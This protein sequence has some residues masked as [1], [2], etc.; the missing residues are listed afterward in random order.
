MDDSV[1]SLSLF[2]PDLDLFDLNRVEVLR[3]P[4][5]T[6]YGAGSVGGTIRYITNRPELERDYGLVEAELNSI[7]GG[8]AGWHLKGM[9]NVALSDS[10]ALRL[11][12]YTT[13]Y[14]GYIDA[15]SESGARDDDVNTWR[16]D[17]CSPFV[18]VG[19]E[20]PGL[21]LAEID[22]S[23]S[24]G[25]M[26]STAKRSSTCS[27]TPIRRPGRPSGSETGSN[28]CCSEKS[29]KM[30]PRCSTSR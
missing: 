14:G 7:A 28:T 22:P 17:R 20:R 2:T 24:V 26:V 4:Q 5:G 12:G 1:V 27:P 3:G 9:A 21:G 11:V 6:L 10:S 16:P 19:R 8:D 29:S 23:A 30:K 25:P 15:L 13:E 18:A